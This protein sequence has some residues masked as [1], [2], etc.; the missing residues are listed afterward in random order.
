MEVFVPATSEAGLVAKPADLQEEPYPSSEA[1][2]GATLFAATSVE[3][4][5]ESFP[6]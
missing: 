2:S 5:E 3:K 1:T 4:L 6:Y